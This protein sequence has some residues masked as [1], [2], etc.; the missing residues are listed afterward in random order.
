MSK[1]MNHYKLDDET[2]L[3]PGAALSTDIIV[4]GDCMKG[5]PYIKKGHGVTTVNRGDRYPRSALKI[6]SERGQHPTQKPLKLMAYMIE[7]YSEPG[8]TVLDFCMGSGGTGV[9]YK[10]L[11]RRFIGIEKDHEIF[12]V[13]KR[14]TKWIT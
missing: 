14:R 8:D 11:D 13:A 2:N 3:E 6:N 10:N 5:E 1:T 9:A 7:T 12:N 4:R